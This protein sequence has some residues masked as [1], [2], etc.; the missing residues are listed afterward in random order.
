M[1]QG[2]GEDEEESEKRKRRP[3]SIIASRVGEVACRASSAGCDFAS[4]CSVYP[5]AGKMAAG[6]AVLFIIHSLVA[7]DFAPAQRLCII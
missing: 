3:H 7:I 5:V 4:T 6:H 1:I 2:G